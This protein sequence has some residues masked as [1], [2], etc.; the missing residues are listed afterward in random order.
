MLAEYD[1]SDPAAWKKR[2]E[3][4]KLDAKALRK[5]LRREN[6]RPEPGRRKLYLKQTRDSLRV[7][8]FAVNAATPST[9]RKR[10]ATLLRESAEFVEGL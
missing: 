9:E 6:G 4:E 8:P 10:I 2:I 3:D 1:V 7:Y 5:V